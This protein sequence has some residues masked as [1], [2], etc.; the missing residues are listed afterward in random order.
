M[1]AD[2]AI[3]QESGD[4]FVAFEAENFQID[5]PPSTSEPFWTV[6]TDTEASGGATLF[7]EDPGA[8]T[9]G[10]PGNDEYVGYTIDF[11]NG[12]DY[13]LYVRRLATGGGGNSFFVA[14]DFDVD[15]TS[16]NFPQ[17]DNQGTSTSYVFIDGDASNNDTIYTVAAG[18]ET[19]TFYVKPREPNYR[20]DRIVLSQDLNLTD[21]QLAA[22]PNSPVPEPASLALLGLGSLLIAGRRRAV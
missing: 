10:Q 16:A 4:N 6:I 11:Q 5:A 17:F 22:L 2:A 8:F 18:G 1:S 7:A 15:P 13:K 21:A 3:I 20:L 14:N 19:V 9:N 12:G